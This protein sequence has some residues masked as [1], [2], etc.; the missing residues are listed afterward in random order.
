MNRTSFPHESLILVCDGAKAL[1]LE[2]AGD[3]QALNL[4]TID[5][6][7]EPHAPTRELGDDRPTR[8]HDSR[9]GSR[10]GAEQ[11]DW[12]EQAE[13]DFL[14]SVAKEFDALVAKRHAKHAVLVAPP[15]ALAVLREAI[16]AETRKVVDAELAKD[17]VK[18]PTYEI[19]R[20][21]IAAAAL[22]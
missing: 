11:T 5:A 15:K 1:F 17:L 4:K 6:R 14:R 22:K 13:S 7:N 9:D 12:H 16:A 2:N 10:S 18:L 21:L 20:H 19:E 8:V 3:A